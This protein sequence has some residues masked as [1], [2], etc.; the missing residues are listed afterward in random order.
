MCPG[1]FG[2][3]TWSIVHRWDCQIFYLC[4]GGKLEVAD[5]RGGGRA[6]LAFVRGGRLVQVAETPQVLELLGI[7][8]A[9]WREEREG[10]I[11]EEG[12]EKRGGWKNEGSR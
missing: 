3:T 5:A 9:L 8:L 4:G 12:R 11:E 10:G 7:T 6:S 2:A 1:W